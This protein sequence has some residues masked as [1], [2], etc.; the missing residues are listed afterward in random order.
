M[1][2]PEAIERFRCFGCSCGVLVIGAG[3]DGSAARAALRARERMLAWHERFSRFLPD[4]ELQ[5]L[6]RDRR[7]R[8]PVTPLMARLA[9]AVRDAGEITGG[10]VDATLLRQLEDA[11][12]TAELG[13]P[14]ELSR[15]LE[16]APARRPAGPSALRGWARLQVDPGGRFLRR[17]PGLALDSGGLAKGLFADVLAE[18]LAG[19]AS[20]AVDCGGDLALGG[21]GSRPRRIEVQSPFD[22]GVLHTFAASR[23]GG[24]AT[25]GIGRRSWLDPSGSPAHHL[26][27]PATGGPAFTGVVQATALAPSALL[28][29]VHA[30]AAVLSGPEGARG[31]LAWGGVL[32]LDDGS[33]VVL[34]P[35]AE[36]GPAAG[37]QAGTEARVRTVAAL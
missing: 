24:V 12:Y 11:G 4:S 26:L 1:S 33:H 18:G 31:W 27:D 3:P 35:P 37:L 23:T 17:P 5:L 30:K 19:H 2:E 15:A 21:T 7:E 6:N 36:R 34:E 28:A 10:L 9:R 13:E 14:L 20:F 22:G 32:V 25:S 29:E 8:I 16:L